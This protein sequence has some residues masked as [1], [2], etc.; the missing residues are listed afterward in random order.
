[1]SREQL[2]PWKKPMGDGQAQSCWGPR[3]GGLGE[4]VSKEPM[5]GE[6]EEWGSR[7]GEDGD[8]LQMFGKTG[9]CLWW[10]C[11]SGSCAGSPCLQD[12]RGLRRWSGSSDNGIDRKATGFRAVP[13][14]P[15]KPWRTVA[16]PGQAGVRPRK[17][18]AQSQGRVCTAGS[19]TCEQ[20]GWREAAR[21]GRWGQAGRAK[22]G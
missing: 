15:G 10:A 22:G 20:C 11:I 17:Q 14:G 4:E 12:A 9:V 16:S 19:G 3:S 7:Q 21:L 6:H 1:M 13:Q 5:A 8:S 18:K 2:C